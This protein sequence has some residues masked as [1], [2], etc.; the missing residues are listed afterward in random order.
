MTSSSSFSIGQGVDTSL[1]KQKIC[2]NTSIINPYTKTVFTNMCIKSSDGKEFYVSKHVLAE[3]SKVFETALSEDP[4]CQY[5]KIDTDSKY[6]LEWLKSFHNVIGQKIESKKINYS[7]LIMLYLQYDMKDPLQKAYAEILQ[8]TTMKPSLVRTIFNI[9]EFAHLKKHV[10]ALVAINRIGS[11]AVKE[12]PIDELATQ[13]AN[14]YN[15]SISD[16]FSNT[17]NK[18]KKLHGLK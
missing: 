18:I 3:N 13:Y 4:D 9:K 6:V 8:L 16:R 15:I 1:K 17:Y 5:I 12:I 2:D 11:L 7:K 10:F 14:L